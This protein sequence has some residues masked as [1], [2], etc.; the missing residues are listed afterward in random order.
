MVDL[1]ILKC[2]YKCIPKTGY[3]SKGDITILMNLL[4]TKCEHVTLGKSKLSLIYLPCSTKIIIMFV[5]V[6][7]CVYIYMLSVWWLHRQETDSHQVWVT[8][9]TLTIAPMFTLTQS[10]CA[11]QGPIYVLNG[12][13][14]H[15]NCA[16][17]NDMLNWIIKNRTI[18]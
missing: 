5:C 17:T 3:F 4:L 18:W 13:V 2:V 16:Q 12:T 10:G 8:V 9:S 11:W 15:L 14:L 7:V 6:C 1:F